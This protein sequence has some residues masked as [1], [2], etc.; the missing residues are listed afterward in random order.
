ML[1]HAFVTTAVKILTTRNEWGDFVGSGSSTLKCRFRE[2]TSLVK[3]NQLE[4]ITTDALAH[5]PADAPIDEESILLIEGHY[6]R[7][8]KVI[9]AK[10]LG[11]TQVQFLKAYLVRTREVV[12]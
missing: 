8:V 4:E 1:E 5:F 7:A 11:S 2:T 6:F 9:K 3:N 12:S 10:A